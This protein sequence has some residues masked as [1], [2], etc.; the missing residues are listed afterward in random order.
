[1]SDRKRDGR[2]EPALYV[3]SPEGGRRNT[4]RVKKGQRRKPVISM[5]NGA[6]HGAST[7]ARSVVRMPNETLEQ[8][9]DIV[10]M[11]NVANGSKLSRA[12]VMR[13]GLKMWIENATDADPKEVIAAVVAA[14]VPRGRKKAR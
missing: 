2:R 6:S 3:A 9:N 1:M 12:S 14:H 13:A 7:L 5:P 4:R 8:L 10:A 11:V